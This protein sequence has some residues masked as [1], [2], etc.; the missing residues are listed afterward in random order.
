MK[1][2]ESEVTSVSFSPDGEMLASA[3]FD[4][5]VKLSINGKFVNGIR[6]SSVRKGYLCLE[7]EGAPVEFKNIRLRKL[8]SP[9]LPDIDLEALA[10]MAPALT[11]GAI[12]F[13]KTVREK[14]ALPR[15]ID[16]YR[17]FVRTVFL[18]T[19]KP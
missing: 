12:I 7:S 10:D 14:H 4:G 13:S 11:D 6:N 19:D 3:G 16:L 8:P 2:H 1:G 5:T 15:Q 18:G 9:D 17:E